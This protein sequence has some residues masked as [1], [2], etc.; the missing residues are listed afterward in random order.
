MAR[1]S[2]PASPEAA[3]RLAVTKQRLAGPLPSKSTKDAI[4][5]LVRDLAY[6]QWDPVTVVAPSHILSLWSRLGDF[7]PSDL[8][9]LLWEEKSLFLH[10]TPV[11]EIVSMADFPIYRSLMG[12]YPRSLSKGWGRQRAYAEEFLAK[13]A[14]LRRKVLA[15]LKGGPLQLDQFEDHARTKRDDGDWN[16]GSDVSMMLYLLLMGG[17]VMVVGHRGNQNLWGLSEQF[18]PHDLPKRELSEEEFEREAVQRSIRVLGTA[19]FTEIKLHW[20]RGRYNRLQLTLAELEEESAIHRVTIE[21]ARKRE[22][23]Y[24]HDND[25]QLLE[26][27]DGAAWRPRM[28]L[29]PPFDN[30]LFNQARGKQ[31]FEFD[32]VREQFLPRAKRRFGT[33]V[34]PILWGDRFIGRI[35]PRLDKKRSELIINAVHAEP[36]APG[37]KDVAAKI[38]ETIARLASFVGASRVTYGSRVPAIWKSGLR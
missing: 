34:L 18:L 31:L 35:D 29:L 6:V 27:L 14:A 21:G 7:R 15:Q 9:E 23:R 3:R 13:H 17:E 12:R 10:W 8:E 38:G 19:T 11:A 24:I 30:M 26:S 1:E 16:P 20:L 36:G 4:R 5:A 25:V 28:S 22:V 2:I 33:Y 32:Y 37:G